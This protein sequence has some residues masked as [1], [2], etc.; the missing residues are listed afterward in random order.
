MLL[1][2]PYLAAHCTIYK[3]YVVEYIN[4]LP[5]DQ[6]DFMMKPK[7]T[8]QLSEPLPDY[9][10]ESGSDLFRTVNLFPSVST[11]VALSGTYGMHIKVFFPLV[12]SP[13]LLSLDLSLS[14]SLSPSPPPPLS[15]SLPLS[16]SFS[17]S[18]SHTRALSRCSHRY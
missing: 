9:T 12:L 4:P 17:L 15:L 16:L 5:P 14:F 3:V 18:L 13:S 7:E 1:S 11:S 10:L 2:W 8:E 6:F